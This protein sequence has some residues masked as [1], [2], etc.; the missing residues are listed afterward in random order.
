VALVLFL[1]FFLGVLLHAAFSS[2]PARAQSPLLKPLGL[3]FW[4]I[5]I[6]AVITSLRYTNFFPFL[7]A[8]ARELAV[9]VNEV[10]AGG[11]VM[12]VLFNFLNYVT[13]FAFLVILLPEIAI[14]QEGAPDRVLLDGACWFCDRPEILFA[15]LNTFLGQLGRSTRHSRIRIPLT[16][17]WLSCPFPG[18]AIF[19]K[20]DGGSGFALILL[21]LAASFTGSGGFRAW[22]RPLVFSCCPQGTEDKTQEQGGLRGRPFPS[23]DPGRCFLF[24][25]LP[26]IKPLPEDGV[27]P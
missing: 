19:F 12:S 6:S 26:E 3:L 17:L 11:A 14:C 15:G 24:C 21:G 7:A 22:I 5:V 23:R 27:E 16:V 4:V 13:G 1:A 8:D 9:N 25:F 20:D 10:R 18:L 2:A